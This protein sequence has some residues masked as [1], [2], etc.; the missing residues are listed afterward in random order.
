MANMLTTGMHGILAQ[1]EKMSWIANNVA[2]TK[3]P[4]YHSREAF[5]SELGRCS[6]GAGQQSQGA[7]TQELDVN[8]DAGSLKQTEKA[9]H[10]GIQGEGMFPVVE[11]G[12]TFYTRAGDFSFNK[13]SGDNGYVLSRPSG[14]TLADSNGQQITFSNV[15]SNFRIGTDGTFQGLDNSTQSSAPGVK[16]QLF[17]NPGTLNPIGNGLY[18]PSTETVNHQGGTVQNTPATPVS[19]GNAGSGIIKQGTLEQSNVDM[20]KEFTDMIKTQRI[21]QANSKSITTANDMLKKA[22][23]NL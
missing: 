19:P 21:Y 14:E 5:L 13:S 18:A 4:G 12:Q 22:I 1:N 9:T 15:P 3:S 2:N 20:I 11:S 8:W 7:K 17:A 10:M 6:D 16:L 23:Q